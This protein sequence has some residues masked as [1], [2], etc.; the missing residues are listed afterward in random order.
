MHSFSVAIPAHAGTN[1]AGTIDMPDQQ[2]VAW[3]VFAHCFTGSRFT[4]AASR[5]C[6][7]LA[8]QGVAC[9]RFDFPGL[10][11]SEGDFAETS[12][13][14]N[15]LDLVSAYH[16]LEET[17][18]APK[19]LI[20][21]SLG[22][23]ASLKA[24]T[25]MPKLK[26]VATIGA[27]F[28]PAHAVLHFADRISE[29]DERGA[30]TLSL[31]G[32]DV[33]IS[34]PFL[35]DLAEINPEQHIPKLRKPLLILHSPIDQTVGIDNAQNIFL[36][37]RYPKSLVALEK[38]DHLLTKP[39]AAHRAADI[40]RAWADEYF[41]DA[42]ELADR[43]P[44][45][46]ASSTSIPAGRFTDL[47]RFD[48]TTITTDRERSLGGKG[49]GLS[50]TSLLLSALAAATSQAIRIA[51]KDQRIRGL[52]NVDVEV[53]RVIGAPEFAMQLRRRISLHGDLTDQERKF[54]LESAGDSCIEQIIT[55]AATIEDR[56]R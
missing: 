49:L 24:A 54:L 45:G 12:F 16:W 22:G 33:T 44:E 35:E 30:V 34:R 36:T 39:G 11:Q 13:S 9:L 32:R 25:L 48:D 53:S 47:V 4:P 51:A 56:D 18:E 37:A 6:K 29:V 14:S 41:T 43:M 46:V 15:V 2:P 8:A 7:R 17:Y 42:D 27:P 5:V 23:A 21:H 38:V 10:G 50:P 55:G 20:G 52:D 26:A 1:M 31:G 28:D 40:I 19:L 3:A